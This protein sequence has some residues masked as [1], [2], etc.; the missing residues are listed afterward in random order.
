MLPCKKDLG[1]LFLMLLNKI[2]EYRVIQYQFVKFLIIGLTNTAISYLV[3]W[4]SYNLFL[5]KNVFLSQC[6]S[7][8]AGIVWSFYWNHKWTFSSKKKRL[9]LFVKFMTVQI[10]LLLLSAGI[11]S[12]CSKDYFFNVNIIW[13][14]V[15]GFMTLLNFLLS[16][17]IVFK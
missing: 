4:L 11:M 5:H 6:C 12:I 13:L 10:S 2:F 17:I 7:Y 1:S 3:F 9:P 8:F 14:I 15:M 16:K